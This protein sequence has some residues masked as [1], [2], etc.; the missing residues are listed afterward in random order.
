MK[1]I[2][3][4]GSPS[5]IMIVGDYPTMAE[6]NLGN[7]FSGSAGS[8]LGNLFAPFGI[9]ANSL[10]KTHYIKIPVPGMSS[11]A[12]KI[13]AEALK[14][15]MEAENWDSL[16]K[17]EILAINPNIIVAC[18]EVALTYL[19]EEHGIK[20]WRGSILHLHPRFELEKIK[21]IPIYSPREIWS[22][23]DKPFVYTQWDCGRVAKIKD[24]AERYSPSETVWI[25]H[26][27]NGIREW[28]K[29]AKTA[30]F[31]TNDIETH[32]GFITCTGFSHDG[33]EAFSIPLLVGSKVDYS[34]AGERYKAIKEVIES[35][36]PIVNQ[37]I[38]YDWKVYESYGLD[39]KNIVGDTML[40][41]HCIYPELPKGLDFLSSIYTDHPYYKDE[42]KKF[43]PRLHNIDRLLKYNA[44]DAL[45]TWQIWKLQQDDAKAFKVYE[46]YHEK[47]H[48][49]FY[50]Y[51]K[52]DD[53]GMRV[54]ELARQKL[55]DKYYPQLEE[56]EQTVSL[57]AEEKINIASPAQ[58][59]R[60]VYDILK[61][62]PKRHQTPS[63]NLVYSTDEE[64]L[65]DLYVNKVTDSG[66]RS[67]L[68]SV[69]RARKL[70]KVIQFL[71]A[72]ISP[73]GYMRTSYKLQG[74]ETGRTSAGK[75][76]EPFFFINDKGRIREGECGGS[77]QT[78]PKHGFEFGSERIGAD[79][80][81]IFIPTPGYTFVEGDLSQAEDRVVCVLAQDFDG[82]S[83]LEKTEFKRNKYGLKDDRHTLTA[84]LIT[85]KEFDEITPDDRQERGKKPRH[86]GNYNMGSGMLAILTHFSNR[87][88]IEILDKFH[89]GNPKIRGIFHAEIRQQIENQRYLVS[90]HGRRRDFFGRVSEDM[91][92]QAFSTIPQATV[93]DHNKLTILRRMYEKYPFP[94]ARPISEAH[95]SLTWEVRNDLVEVFC[96]DYLNTCNTPIDFNNCSLSRDIQ[97]VIPGEMTIYKSNWGTH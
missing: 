42:G 23:D 31:I 29:R 65:E 49:V 57:V 43:D 18:G 70:N 19:T 44:R 17:D 84:C 56:I 53:F 1:L 50:I 13:R 2:N 27:A 96:V 86:A 24:Y 36:I 69:I 87:T 60:F 7:S 62:P 90:P 75:S 55:K 68:H 95:D 5:T 8:L 32:H 67:L 3:S 72:N 80:R 39:F 94:L 82:L 64:T 59:G 74:T 16:I 35:G 37:N 46:F 51:K 79:L 4:S 41:A 45:V 33:N 26:T 15:A 28:W 92:K 63:G 93:S 22:D 78:I 25:C 52:M 73:D 9:K 66:R 58:V 54:D 89:S 97:L 81:T 91:F 14:G 48:P 11:P 6:Y 21:V 77:F 40:M 34:S 85:G 20:K 47:V 12:K 71:E 10:Y 83:L 61:C 88:C 76:I 30:E 38:K